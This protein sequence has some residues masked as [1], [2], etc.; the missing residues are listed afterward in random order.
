MNTRE[1]QIRFERMI[2][3]I[4]PELA[5]K[6][7]LN[8]DTIMYFLNMSQDRYIKENFLSKAKIQDNIEFLKKRSDV[9]KDLIVRA[10]ITSSGNHLD[11]G[12]IYDLPSNYLLYITSQSNITRSDE[13]NESSALYITNRLILHDELDNVITTPIN[14]PILRQPCVLLEGQDDLVLYKDQYTTI[15]GFVLIYLKEPSELVLGT[16]G[17]GETT[18]CELA[19]HTHQE[20]VEKAANLYIEE[21]RYKLNRAQ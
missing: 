10:S 3:S 16:P 5:T 6:D 17:T 18:T 20:I 7:K 8:S 14:K 21:Y 11:G 2:H 1:M 9:L 13:Y 19:D 4:D 15:S 12:L